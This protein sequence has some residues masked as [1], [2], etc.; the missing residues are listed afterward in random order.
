MSC[1]GFPL[2]GRVLSPHSTYIS[3]GG[4]G[5]LQTCGT[6]RYD[7]PSPLCRCKRTAGI[8][9]MGQSLPVRGGVATI[10]GCRDL[11][12]MPFIRREAAWY[13]ED[14][15]ILE[16]DCRSRL[17]K[18]FFSCLLALTSAFW[19]AASKGEILYPQVFIP[20]PTAFSFQNHF[21]PVNASSHSLTQQTEASPVVEASLVL[22]RSCI[23]RYHHSWK[24]MFNISKHI[25]KIQCL[26]RS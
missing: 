6:G 25:N 3:F 21:L 19:F 14:L 10:V 11:R 22:E 13:P 16:A 9:C 12:L 26:R 5:H 4:D 23:Y 2:K 8:F 17:Q 18:W 24:K 1:P 15:S 20:S 7:A